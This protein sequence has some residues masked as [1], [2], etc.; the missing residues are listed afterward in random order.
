MPKYTRYQSH[1]PGVYWILG[2]TPDGREEKI[3]YIYY[4]RNGQRVEEKAGRQFRD[5]M[6]AA[7]AAQIRTRRIEGDPSNR[8]RRQE[9]RQRSWT[10]TSLWEDYCAHRVRNKGLAVDQSRFAKFIAP[11]LGHKEPRELAPLDLERLRHGMVKSRYAPQTIKHAVNLLLRLVNHGARL[12]LCAALPFKAPTLRVHNLKTEDLTR[13]QLASLWRAM[14]EEPDTIAAA[15]M[16]LAL[17]TG[18]RRGEIFRLRWADV[19]FDKGFLH[20]RRPK[21]GKDQ[22]IPLN[23]A[24]RQILAALPREAGSPYVFP[25]RSG[26]LRTRAPRR[27]EAIRQRAELPREFRPLHGLRH[28]YASLLAS[29]GRVTLYTLQKLLTHKSS[30]MTSRYAHLRDEALRQASDLAGDLIGQAV[31]DELPGPFPGVESPRP[32]PGGQ[33]RKKSDKKGKPGV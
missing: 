12:G 7:R 28:V 30:A 27:I 24:A 16:R 22:S 33:G 10:L 4:R 2:K 6:T 13:E 32:L 5:A 18:L 21:G 25:G 14:D 29:S 9:A 20:L 26:G 23:Q 19:D 8:V 15:F 17:V 1:Y 3:F 31:T 11:S